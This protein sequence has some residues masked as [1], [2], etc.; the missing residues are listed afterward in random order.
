MK[1]KNDTKQSAPIINHL[2]IRSAN[3]SKKDISD[4]RAAHVS[5]E[6]VYYP[7]RTRLYDMYDD[8]ML[9]GH[10]YGIVSKRIDA[11]LN[12]QL[13]FEREGKKVAAMDEL[14]QSNT[15]RDIV[16][17]IMQTPFWGLSGLEFIPGT[18]LQFQ[19]IPRKH[20]KPDTGLITYEQN[21]TEGMEYASFRNIWVIG[22]N[23]DLGVLLRCAPY[24]LYKRGNLSDWAQYIEL[25]GQ[26]VRIIYYDAYDTQTKAELKELLEES[27]SSLSLMIPKQAEFEMRDG[28]FTNGD[29][30]LQH[31]FMQ[32]L[33]DEMSVIVLGN[34]ETTT[35][36]TGSGYAQSK[37]H[38]GQQ[39]EIT[40]SD[41]VYTA[42]MLNH[43]AFIAVLQS[44]GYPVGDGK[45]RFSKDAD[46]EFLKQRMEIDLQLAQR[47]PVPESYWYE[48]YGI[49]RP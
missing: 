21:G 47:I 32:A 18:Q 30:S 34:T 23:N 7:T 48:T 5:A 49:P 25:Y 10:L 9:D 42:N 26:P 24:A 3:R 36:S 27:G 41:L 20:I 43:P 44:Y 38:N 8:V 19:P 6:S 13:Y 12:K 35:S 37:V 17:I 11:V 4:W 33:N 46:L 2:Q 39:Y 1:E 15:F 28:K 40:R 29:G 22:G 45:F 14:I 31:T 16:R